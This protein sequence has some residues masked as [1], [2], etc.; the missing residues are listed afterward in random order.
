MSSPAR[1]RA[2]G[3]GAMRRRPRSG[4]EDLRRA[5]VADLAIEPV[6]QPGALHFQLVD[7]LVRS[8]IDLLFD[9][10]DLV[11]HSV[12][13]VELLAELVVAGLEAVDGFAVVR[14]LTK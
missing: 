10:V 1:H 14:E 12:I 9:A 3:R 13:L 7:F 4:V 6:L 5:G 8:E 2:G 11:I